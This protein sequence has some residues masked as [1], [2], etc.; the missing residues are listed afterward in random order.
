MQI[1]ALMMGVFLGVGSQAFSQVPSGYER[2][3]GGQFI[4]CNKE[5]SLGAGIY[6]LDRAEG[7]FLFEMQPAAAL[8]SFAGEFEIVSYIL[9]QLAQVNPTRAS[10]YRMWLQELIVNQEFTKDIY[11]QPLPDGN[12][13]AVPRDCEVKQAAIFIT[14]PSREKLRFIFDKDLWD[15]ASP[16]DRAYLVLHELIYR[17][18]LQEENHHENSMA[19]RY[20][21]AWL[22][23]H[24]ENYQFAELL[25]VLQSIRFHA[26]DFQGVPLVLTSFVGPSTVVQAPIEWYPGTKALKKAVLGYSFALPV[27][28]KTFKR[29]CDIPITMNGFV[30]SVEF[31]PSGKV[32]RLKFSGNFVEYGAPT[33]KPPSQECFYYDGYANDLLLDENGDLI[34]KRVSPEHVFLRFE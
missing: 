23:A 18:A 3:N 32:K 13:V 25:S 22:F 33:G 17:E 7:K 1:F 8:N 26:I 11:F 19:T 27:A 6:S 9:N 20:F 29:R 34:E 2:G 28:G 21:N 15:Q 12:K 30:N 24:V 10:L 31:Y 4:S 16:L 14:E 5:S